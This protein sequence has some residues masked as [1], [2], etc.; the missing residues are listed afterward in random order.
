MIRGVA[1]AAAFF[2]LVSASA[3]A[4]AADD[5]ALSDALAWIKRVDGQITKPKYGAL[6]QKEL[7][8]LSELRIGGHRKSDKKHIFVPAEEFKHLAALPALTK[9]HLGENDGL[10]DEA[11]VHVGKLTGLKELVLWDAPLTDAGLAHVANLKGL[12]S[13]DLAFA[14]KITTAAL[15]TIVQLPNLER[16]VISG[17]QINDVSLLAKAPKLQ[18]L[19]VGKLNPR[20]LDELKQANPKLEIK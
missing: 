5:A 4:T 12:T 16:L 17:T 15:P 14:T 10:T 1:I 6:T 9:L 3:V 20:G 7:E 2:S 18:F 11:M 19:Q 13:L 8:T